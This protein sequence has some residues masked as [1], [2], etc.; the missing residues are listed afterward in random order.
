MKRKTKPLITGGLLGLA[1]LGL[2]PQGAEAN[3]SLPVAVPDPNLGAT[4]AEDP[5]P[6]VVPEPSAQ[7]TAPQTEEQGAAQPTWTPEADS[8]VLAAAEPAPAPSPQPK[9]AAVESTVPAPSAQA[10]IVAPE[11]TAVLPAPAPDAIAPVVEPSPSLEISE[12]AI[13]ELAAA[14]ALEPRPADAVPQGVVLQ[15][16]PEAIASPPVVAPAATPEPSAPEPPAASTISTEPSIAP[17]PAAAKPLAQAVQLP[18]LA[19]AA[20]ANRANDDDGQSDA[21]A[22]A[23]AVTPIRSAIPPAP[24]ATARPSA[25]QP[26]SDVATLRSRAAAVQ[27]LLHD[28]RSAYGIEAPLTATDATATPAAPLRQVSRP[29]TL[30][31]GPQLPPL[32]SRSAR[33]RP[34]VQPQPVA[35]A[36]T[37]PAA[38][39]PQ[40]SPL[41][42]QPPNVALALPTPQ[43]VMSSGQAVYLTPSNSGNTPPGSS[44]EVA[45]SPPPVAQPSAVTT[46]QATPSTPEADQVRDD[47]RIEPLTT[48]ANPAQSFPPSPNAGI[49]S[50]FGAEWG[51]VFFS[52]SLSGADRL[53]AEADGSLSMGF[54]LGDARRAVGVELAYNLQSIRR[55]GE[56]G[57]FDAKVHRQVYS[58]DTTQVAAAVGVNNFVSYGADTAGTSTSVYGVVTAAHLLQPEHPVN[59]LPITTTLG[60]GSGYFSGDNSDVGVIAGVGLQ[61]HPQFSINTA[62]SG[63]GLNVG[64]SIVPE[65]TIP[66]TLNLLYGDIGNNTRAGSVAVLSIGYGFNFGPRF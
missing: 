54:G 66:L 47:L 4:L 50:A 9:P 55:F 62:W 48:A 53:R 15:R 43:P 45:A 57:G 12:H 60:A 6:V 25:R 17:K 13:A 52:A 51:D 42:G 8:P 20:P 61:V 56:N 35:A 29:E 14:S 22:I 46:A 2:L 63:A 1:G 7:T 38:N 19:P 32:P 27:S 33:R 30:N 64:A 11:A 23:P 28:L 34:A 24:A 49:P 3:T 10:D 41:P 26:A 65:P 59:R 21:I 39:A 58:S 37:A 5:H 36:I 31:R 16:E 44:A 40:L 18:E